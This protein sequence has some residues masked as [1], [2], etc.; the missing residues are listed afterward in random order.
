MTRRTVQRLVETFALAALVGLSGCAGEGNSPS[1][2]TPTPLP[3]GTSGNTPTPGATP[4]SAPTPMPTGGGAIT[5]APNIESPAGFAVAA[6]DGGFLAVFAAAATDQSSEIFGVRLAG[7]GS[8]I[9]AEPFLV[10]VA[11]GDPQLHQSSPAVGF[12]G[13]TYAV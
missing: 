13:S 6:G 1:G 8:V 7:D 12:D 2:P 5:I 9:D 3:T 10:S 4:T 11:T